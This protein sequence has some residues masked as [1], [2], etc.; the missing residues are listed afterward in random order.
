ML[1]DGLGR[2][3]KRAQR[4]ARAK[5][6]G[7][8]KK[9]EDE[10]SGG[11]SKRQCGAAP[12]GDKKSIKN[13][14][15]NHIRRR[16]PTRDARRETGVRA[17]SAGGRCSAQMKAN[18]PDAL[19]FVKKKVAWMSQA[20]RET[21]QGREKQRAARLTKRKRPRK[22]KRGRALAQTRRAAKSRN[23]IEVRFP[24]RPAGRRQGPEAISK[25]AP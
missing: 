24:A 2:P 1:V 19:F 5:T 14:F 7:A 16:A 6:I 25:P 18:A 15:S 23:S 21:P 8:P 4:P 17:K 13:H 12:W 10:A 11:W 9:T 22:R 20:G 3:Q